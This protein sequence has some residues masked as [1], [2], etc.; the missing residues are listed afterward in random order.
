[1]SET[2][3]AQRLVHEQQIAYEQAQIDA[4]TQQLARLQGVIDTHR[5]EIAR[6]EQLIAA[7]DERE[8]AETITE[9]Q[10][11]FDE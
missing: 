7:L 4:T 8:R 11:A 10:E 1:M 2:T 6:Q 3:T 5:A 9:I